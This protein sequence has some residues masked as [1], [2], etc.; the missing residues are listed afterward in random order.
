MMGILWQ[1]FLTGIFAFN[2]SGPARPPVKVKLVADRDAVV[3]GQPFR[4]GVWIR[5]PEGWHIYWKNSG[6]S[7]LPTRL[8]LD[9]PSGLHP[10]PWI[11]PAPRLFQDP[12][13]ATTFGY[14][15]EVV[16]QQRITTDVHLKN[17]TITLAGEV[18]WLVCREVCIPGRQKVSLKLAV[19]KHARLADSDLLDL[20][21]TRVPVCPNHGWKIQASVAQNRKLLLIEVAPPSGIMIRRITF[22]PEDRNHLA[23]DYRTLTGNGTTLKVKFRKPIPDDIPAKGV[24]VIETL[25]GTLAFRTPC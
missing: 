25:M 6:E 17:K 19:R 24:V 21:M 8:E 4:V 22:F 12:G 13:G 14:T 1:V 10:G 18:R 5:V 7:G 23:P 2:M 9:Y 3:P 15:G 20:S 16:I 11:W